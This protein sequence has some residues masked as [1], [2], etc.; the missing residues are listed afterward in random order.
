MLFCYS[1]ISTFGSFRVIPIKARAALGQ[2]FCVFQ[3]DLCRLGTS[4]GVVDVDGDGHDDLVIS[5]Q[6]YGPTNNQTGVVTALLSRGTYKGT[7]SEILQ[8]YFP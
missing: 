3:P 7:V 8:S 2:V 5:D 1:E 4:L 6:Y